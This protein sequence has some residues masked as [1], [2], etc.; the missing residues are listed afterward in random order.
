M[1]FTRTMPQE[2]KD[3]IS[4]K[5]TGRTHTDETK[6][7]ISDGLKQAWSR[8]PKNITNSQEE[9]HGTKD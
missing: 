4:S 7:K 2:V 5:L 1:G 9:N 8:I 3:K 6:Q